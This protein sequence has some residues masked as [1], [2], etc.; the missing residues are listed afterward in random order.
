MEKLLKVGYF[1]RLMS[2][3]SG[4]VVELELPMDT[5]VER[6]YHGSAVITRGPL[7]Y[8]LP[9]EEEW[10]LVAGTPP[11]G[12]WEVY[13]LS[14]WNYCLVVDPHSP[15]D[16]I[17][18]VERPVGMRPFSPEG[19]PVQIRV[20]GKYFADWHLEGSSAGVLPLSPVRCDGPEVELTL[21]PY[22]CTNLR[23][24]EFPFSDFKDHEGG[25]N[26]GRE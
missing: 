14:S 25:R 7:V 15:D 3:E 26:D 22:G 24:T 12:D 4:D 2:V 11:F 6:G 13:P 23:V 19:A 8:A 1:C 10:K 9:V 20:K 18:V 5:K 17:Q 16:Y 21:I